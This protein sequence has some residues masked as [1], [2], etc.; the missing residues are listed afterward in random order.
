[1]SGFSL[2]LIPVMAIAGVQVGSPKAAA[3]PYRLLD[4]KAPANVGPER[5]SYFVSV[6]N[7]LE[8]STVEELICQVIDK[9]NRRRGGT[10]V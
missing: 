8:N 5:L 6:Q 9:K 7:F 10:L 4:V 3:I 2:L 1:M